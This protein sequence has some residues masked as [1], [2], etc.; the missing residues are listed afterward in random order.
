MGARRVHM[1]AIRC[2]GRE[3]FIDGSLW[4]RWQ[5]RREMPELS[6]MDRPGWRGLRGGMDELLE[7]MAKHC[8]VLGGM[9]PPLA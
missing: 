6:C 1:G 9:Y 5:G 2:L 4:V 3:N 7:V 8:G